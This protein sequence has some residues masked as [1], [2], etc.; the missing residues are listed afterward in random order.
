[1]K[2]KTNSDRTIL[3]T[4]AV[5]AFATAFFINENKMGSAYDW[6]AK[7]NTAI[8]CGSYEPRSMIYP[9]P[10]QKRS[11]DKNSCPHLLAAPGLLWINGSKKN[12]IHLC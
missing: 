2:Q 12:K 4:L 8:S 11:G 10:F 9:K 5:L 1:M 7:K 3:C 6:I